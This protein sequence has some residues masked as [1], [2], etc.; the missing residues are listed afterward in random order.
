MT[1]EKI[2]LKKKSISSKIY[3][4][5]PHF[6]KLISLGY[7]EYLNHLIYSVIFVIFRRTK[8]IIVFYTVNKE[9]SLKYI[10]YMYI[11]FLLYEAKFAF[12]VTSATCLLPFEQL[13]Q[14]A[15]CCVPILII[16][17]NKTT[18]NFAILLFVLTLAVENILMRNPPIF[19][20]ADF[21]SY[22]ISQN[23]K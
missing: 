16:Q 1:P 17:L 11:F 21:Y 20:R 18:T 7:R 6:N 14:R 13:F 19:F 15:D 4:S 9:P 5:D 2:K 10:L 23:K 8:I 22:F 3:Y 12:F